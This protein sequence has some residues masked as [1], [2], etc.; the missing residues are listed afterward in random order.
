MFSYLTTVTSLHQI[1]MNVVTRSECIA[2]LD[3]SIPMGVSIALV[4]QIS[5]A[6]RRPEAVES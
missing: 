6:I 2:R 1:V 3:A 5:L 4:Q